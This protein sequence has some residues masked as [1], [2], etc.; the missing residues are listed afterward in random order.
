MGTDR[1]WVGYWRLAS[2]L[3]G[4]CCSHIN[5]ESDG[6]GNHRNV[7][8]CGRR[9]ARWTKWKSGT[10]SC[11]FAEVGD[12]YHAGRNQVYQSPPPRGR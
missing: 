9:R 10:P 5:C 7:C 3:I 11:A 8:M 1:G 4:S 12:T 2:S 6:F